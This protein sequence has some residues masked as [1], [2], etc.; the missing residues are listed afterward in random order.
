MGRKVNLSLKTDLQSKEE[1]HDNWYKNAF[2]LKKKQKNNDTIC[3][4]DNI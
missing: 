1:K 3:Q 4:D 2:Q